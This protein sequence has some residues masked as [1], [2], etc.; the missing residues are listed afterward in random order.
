MDTDKLRAMGLAVLNAPEVAASGEAVSA[1]EDFEFSKK[2]KEKTAGGCMIS[3]MMI[4]DGTYALVL[5]LD[6]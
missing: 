1:M 2:R 4:P 3:F 6:E 5:D